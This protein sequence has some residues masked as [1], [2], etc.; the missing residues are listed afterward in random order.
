MPAFTSTIRGHHRKLKYF[1][2][3]GISGLYYSSHAKIFIGSKSKKAINSI[4]SKLITIGIPEN[5]LKTK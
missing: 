1:K 2:N 4:R 3:Y 5:R